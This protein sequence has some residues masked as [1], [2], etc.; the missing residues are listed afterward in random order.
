MKAQQ[1]GQP[2]DQLRWSAGWKSPTE[3]RASGTDRRCRTCRYIVDADAVSHLSASPKCLLLGLA[4]RSNAL[5][6]RWT[7]ISMIRL[8]ECHEEES[9]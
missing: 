8:G 2:S 6:D 7:P 5:C 9:E 4:T 3:R 1:Y